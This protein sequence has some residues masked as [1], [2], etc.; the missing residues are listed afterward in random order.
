MESCTSVTII[1]VIIISIVIVTIFTGETQMKL[2]NILLLL[3]DL[4]GIE[5]ESRLLGNKE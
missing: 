1:V 2:V 5:V 4:L 3:F